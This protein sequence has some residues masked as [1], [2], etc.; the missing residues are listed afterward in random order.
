MSALSSQG[1]SSQTVSAQSLEACGNLV[2]ASSSMSLDSQRRASAAQMASDSGT[3][4]DRMSTTSD[5]WDYD[6]LEEMGAI[7]LPGVVLSG[8]AKFSHE[9][10]DVVGLNPEDEVL[11]EED[12][13]A[14]LFCMK[15]EAHPM[16]LGVE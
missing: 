10:Q 11:S 6:E 1:L 5:S 16:D 14:A 15:E 13:M 2:K 4:S 9:P 12:N 8:D 3:S 7:D